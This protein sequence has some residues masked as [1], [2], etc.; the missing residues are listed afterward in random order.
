M[1]L[2]KCFAFV[3]LVFSPLAAHLSLFADSFS[4]LPLISTHT[5][6]RSRFDCFRFVFCVLSE[7]DVRTEQNPYHVTILL[8]SCFTSV[9]Y[10]RSVRVFF[11]LFSFVHLCGVAVAIVVA[12]ELRS[13][14]KCVARLCSQRNALSKASF[15]CVCVSFFCCFLHFA[16]CISTSSF[17]CTFS[18]CLTFVFIC[19]FNMRRFVLYCFHLCYCCLLI[20]SMISA[21]FFYS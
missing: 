18:C 6:T 16:L 3:L 19:C 15:T 7:W 8:H 5:H 14:Y 1:H 12:K 2:S 21:F 9:Q 17:W 20:F 4:R 10:E 11:S 13:D